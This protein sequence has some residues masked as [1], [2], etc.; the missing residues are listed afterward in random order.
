MAWLRA[1][2]EPT[3]LRLLVLMEG[4]DLNVSDLM[5]ILGQSQPRISRHLKLLVEAGLAERSQEGA[6]AYFRT[7]DR[8]PA[9]IFLSAIL[10]GLNRDD[11]VLAVDNEKLQ[12]VRDSRSRRAAD[13]FADN[14][15]QWNRIRSLHVAEAD[16]EAEMLNLGIGHAPK[17]MLDLGTGTG[18]ILELF[19]PHVERGLGLDVSHDMLAVA[20]SALAAANLPQMQVRFGDVYHLERGETY[21]LV[22]L[23]QVLHFLD[24]PA[25]ALREARRQ[26]AAE[27]RLLIVDF[28]PHD[29]EFLREDH[30]HLRLGI[31][32]DQ[33]SRWLD[34]VD[35]EI[36]ESRTL[37]PSGE[38]E[39]A[40]TVALWLIG[41]KAG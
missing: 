1:A 13:Y 37:A 8:G 23:H 34:Q 25:L 32:D 6:W 41:H 7:V 21:D 15:D 12:A 19:A 28:A 2:G 35:M 5:S 38:T 3:R 27:G 26:L 17:T 14:A 40:V 18:R 22:V 24:D 16:V 11:H 31:S 10:D 4:V 9:R 30:A 36:I 33:L 39:N 29:F 20:R